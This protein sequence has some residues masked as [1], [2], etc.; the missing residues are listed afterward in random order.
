MAAALKNRKQAGS[1]TCHWKAQHSYRYC[2]GSRREVRA[3]ASQVA[4]AKLGTYCNCLAGGAVLRSE[5]QPHAREGRAASKPPVSRR[6]LESNQR[7][8]A[9]QKCAQPPHSLGA[10]CT[11]LPTQRMGKL[12]KKAAKP[13]LSPVTPCYI[14]RFLRSITGNLTTHTARRQPAAGRLL[15]GARTQKLT[16]ALHACL[17]PPGQTPIPPSG[18]P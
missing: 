12:G 18:L 13:R 11:G 8:T 3:R 5:A 9:H 15:P 4:G 17:C 14:P 1:T 2:A 10:Q 6:S 7:A 16:R